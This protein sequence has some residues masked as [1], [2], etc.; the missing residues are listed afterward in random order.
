MFSSEGLGS[1]EKV[2][3]RVHGIAD[4]YF[5]SDRLEHAFFASSNLARYPDPKDCLDHVRVE[6]VP[7]IGPVTVGE[8]SGSFCID[9]PPG[10]LA[11]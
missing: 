9:V 1:A 4:V 7:W 5:F 2:P 11:A 8:V 10:R 6:R 3:A